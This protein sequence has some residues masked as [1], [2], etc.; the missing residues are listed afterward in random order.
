MITYKNN[1]SYFTCITNKINGH[2]LSPVRSW[3]CEV[4]QALHRYIYNQQLTVTGAPLE[5]IEEFYPSVKTILVVVNPWH[6]MLDAYRRETINKNSLFQYDTSRRIAFPEYVYTRIS[7]NKSPV[8][9]IDTARYVKDDQLHL[10][11]CMFKL[12]NI[13]HDFKV[14]QQYFETDIPVRVP[15]LT[16]Y[17]QHYTKETEIL[18]GEAY[19]TDVDYFGYAF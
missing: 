10:A 5:K 2:L 7:A 12:D 8:N 3:F 18:V 14:L 13:A 16:E 15:P 1:D 17:R 4:P 19:A 9:Q 6:A 11:T